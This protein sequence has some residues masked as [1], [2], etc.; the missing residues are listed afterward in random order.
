M[1][2]P[3]KSVTADNIHHVYSYFRRLFDVGDIDIQDASLVDSEKRFDAMQALSD[4]PAAKKIVAAGAMQSWMD[5]HLSD[6]GRNWLWAALRQRAHKRKNKP[7]MVAMDPDVHFDL[8]MMA[9]EHGK[10]LSEM[11]Q[12]LMEMA[13]KMKKTPSP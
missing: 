7:A 5:E 8:K 10:T 3:K 13:K 12:E 2:R 11:V 4:V 6:Q 9:E 1:G